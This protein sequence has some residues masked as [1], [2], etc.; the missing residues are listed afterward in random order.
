MGRS[1]SENPSPNALAQRLSRQRKKQQQRQIYGQDVTGVDADE[2]TD[3]AASSDIIPPGLIPASSPAFDRQSFATAEVSSLEEEQALWVRRR[4]EITEL[5]L[6]KRRGDLISAIEAK[7]QSS[8][9]GRRFRSVLDRIPANLPSHLSPDQR[10]V[11]EAAIK[12][13]VALALAEL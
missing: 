7:Q 5:E 13:A 3:Y 12:Q 10:S 11:C 2:R 8:N 6:A 9:R 1:R 4:R